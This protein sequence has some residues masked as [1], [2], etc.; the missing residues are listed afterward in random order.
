MFVLLVFFGKGF[1]GNGVYRVV[2]NKWI[3]GCVN[4]LL[5]FYVIYVGKGI[6]NGNDVKV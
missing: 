2:C 1:N 6:V 5:V 3:Q 4:E